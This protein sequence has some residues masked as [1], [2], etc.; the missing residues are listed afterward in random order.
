MESSDFIK[1]YD[2]PIPPLP[3]RIRWKRKGVTWIA[4]AVTTLLFSEPTH[5]FIDFL[6]IPW[7][8]DLGL[9]IRDNVKAGRKFDRDLEAWSNRAD[10]HHR[11][12][13]NQ[14]QQ[15]ANRDWN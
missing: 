1:P 13:M 11:K 14:I 12:V 15:Y 8:I 10:A 7:F 3:K 5:G 2:E 4:I 6:W 9:E